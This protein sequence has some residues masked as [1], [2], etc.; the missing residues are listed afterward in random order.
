MDFLK[1]L[2]SLLFQ[3]KQ[4]T[5][6]VNTQ[7]VTEPVVNQPITTK[8]LIQI[9]VLRTIKSSKS[10]IGQFFVNNVYL[11]NTLEPAETTP[12]HVGH[13]CIPLGT[14]KASVQFF[15][16]DGKKH[17]ELQ[18]VPGRTE[19]FIHGGNK[20]EDTLGCIL[21]G[22]YNASQPDW[23]SSSQVELAKFEAMLVGADEIA[24]TVTE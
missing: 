23:V 4:P 19:I 17:L 8:K 14:Y 7:V 21:L 9:K 24:I 6:T 3:S 18:N 5:T 22:I 13:P 2:L 1:S 15:G 10:T 11:C 20:P 16:T 12:V